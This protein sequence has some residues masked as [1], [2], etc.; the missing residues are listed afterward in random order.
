MSTIPYNL[1]FLSTANTARSI[2]AEAI[3]R[4]EGIGRFA[5]HSA[6]CKP[7]GFIHPHAITTLETYGYSADGLYSKSWDE[8]TV[9][10]SPE[11]DFIITVCDAAAGEEC[12]QWPGHPVT[13]HWLIEDPLRFQESDVAQ[14]RAFTMVFNYLKNRIDL[15]LATPLHRLDKLSLHQ[16]IIEIGQGNN[17]NIK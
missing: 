5:A 1:L 14:Q 17:P 16:H 6:G 7:Q 9:L 4:A 11:M 13:A 15:L 10:N 12:P 3:L 8:F 2:M